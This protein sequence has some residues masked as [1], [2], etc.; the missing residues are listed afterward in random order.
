MEKILA[1]YLRRVIE[2]LEQ[3][4]AIVD[5]DLPKGIERM[6]ESILTMEKEAL[7]M[8][9]IINLLG[10]LKNDL[11]VLVPEYPPSIEKE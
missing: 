2:Q 1:V 10:D 5:E 9:P 3:A 11:C 7:C 4:I 6:P 8:L